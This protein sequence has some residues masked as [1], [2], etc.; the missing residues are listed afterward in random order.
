MNDIQNSNNYSHIITLPGSALV[1]PTDVWPCK[2]P[3]YIVATLAYTQRTAR[4][5]CS[6]KGCLRLCRGIF[7]CQGRRGQSAAGTS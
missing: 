1:T 4:W 3:A 6:H 2:V 5:G 7:K